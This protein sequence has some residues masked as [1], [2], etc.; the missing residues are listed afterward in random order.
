MK[1]SITP[2]NQTNLLEN[3]AL[4]LLAVF[5]SIVLWLVVVNVDDP[6]QTK[7]FTT[8]V[9]VVNADV[10]TDADAIMKYRRAAVR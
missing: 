5:F 4:K 7:T 10:L 1:Q 6:T 8:N 3:W 2:K 9:T